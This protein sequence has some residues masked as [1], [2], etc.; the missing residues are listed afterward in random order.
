M[1]MTW[2]MDNEKPEV[3]YIT[4]H[5]GE[6]KD[7][8]AQFGLKGHNGVDFRTRLVDSPLGHRFIDAALPGKVIETTNQGGKGYGK[9]VRLE[10]EGGAQT[11]YAHLRKFYVKEGQEVHQGQRIGLS[12]NSGFS[13][14][15]HLH[16]GYRPAGWEKIYNNGFKGYIDPYPYL[17]GRKEVTTT[18]P[19]DVAE[20]AKDSW[21]WARKNNL[22]DTT[23]P[24]DEV[25]AEWV[26]TMIHNSIK[27]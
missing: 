9:F 1:K 6:N 26:I 23:K 10:H 15:P 16:F 25:T 18:P 24:K 19:E 20:W 14:G 4:Q 7:I 22:C 5:F 3:I 11:V 21:E 12:N 13:T 27:K 17:K 2:P 8:Y